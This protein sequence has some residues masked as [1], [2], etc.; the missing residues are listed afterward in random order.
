[1]GF[2]PVKTKRAGKQGGFNRNFIENIRKAKENG[3]PIIIFPQG[4]WSRK[5][6]P[7]LPYETGASAIAKSYGLP[8]MPAYIEG[9]D[10]WGRGKKVFVNIGQSINPEGKTKEEITA[11]IESAIM[12][13]SEKSNEQ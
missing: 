1:M 9:A 2:I 5:F 10:S 13:L 4:H 8:I 6:D 7:K 3:E 11:E 12:S